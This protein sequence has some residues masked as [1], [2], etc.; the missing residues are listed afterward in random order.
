MSFAG[1]LQH[2]DEFIVALRAFHES[3]VFQRGPLANAMSEVITQKRIDLAQ[4]RQQL[5]DRGETE[6]LD[7]LNRFVDLLEPYLEEGGA[8]E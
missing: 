8:E 6:L 3:T 4:V 5:L 1:D 7:S 2:P